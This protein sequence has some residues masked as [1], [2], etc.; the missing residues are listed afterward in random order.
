MRCADLITLFLRVLWWHFKNIFANKQLSG[1]TRKDKETTRQGC[2]QKPP[3]SC[4]AG[5]LNNKGS[6]GSTGKSPSTEGKG[7]MSGQDC[8][9]APSGRNR[10][11]YQR[12]V[13]MFLYHGETECV[14]E[15][16]GI[17]LVN[18]RS[19]TVGRLLWSDGNGLNWI[20]GGKRYTLYGNKL[21]SAT[22]TRSEV[23]R[24]HGIR[25]ADTT[26][27]YPVMMTAH[28]PEMSD[29]MTNTD[30]CDIS[31][32]AYV[33]CVRA[34]STS[35][36]TIIVVALVMSSLIGI[37]RADGTEGSEY[38]DH[39]KE[40]MEKHNPLKVNPEYVSLVRGYILQMAAF[41]VWVFVY[42]PLPTLLS[43]V[44]GVYRSHQFWTGGVHVVASLVLS[45]TSKYTII[46]AIVGTA[47][48]PFWALGCSVAWVLS[49]DPQNVVVCIAVLAACVIWKVGLE[50]QMRPVADPI[51]GTPMTAYSVVKMN[52]ESCALCIMVS[53]LSAAC[54]SGKSET[55]LVIAA[56]V[57]VMSCLL[58]PSEEY[59]VTQ[60]NAKGQV[61]T[62]RVLPKVQARNGI[63]FKLRAKMAATRTSEAM[64]ENCFR[65]Y[66]GMYVS[67]GF[68]YKGLMWVLDHGIEEGKP[69]KFQGETRFAAN[70]REP[71]RIKLEH[72]GITGFGVDG[73][74]VV[75]QPKM[76]ESISDGW[77]TMIHYDPHGKKCASVFYGVW[78]DKTLTGF[79]DAQA[80]DSGSPV[81]DEN[82][83]LEAVYMGGGTGVGVFSPAMPLINKPPVIEPEEIEEQEPRTDYEEKEQTSV[84]IREEVG[85]E[86]HTRVCGQSGELNEIK[87]LKL[88]MFALMESV[89]QMR[90]LLECQGFEFHKKK[91]KNKKRA[92]T[93][94]D[95][96]RKRTSHYRAYPRQNMKMFTD[97]EYEHLLNSGIPKETIAATARQRWVDHCEKN[98]MYTD[99]EQEISSDSDSDESTT[100]GR[101]ARISVYDY[102]TYELDAHAMSGMTFVKKIGANTRIDHGNGVVANYEN[103]VPLEEFTRVS[104]EREHLVEAIE[105]MALQAE[106]YQAEIGNL[107]AEVE[108]LEE[109]RDR[110]DTDIENLECLVLRLKQDRSEQEE[111]KQ[112]L[113]SLINELQNRKVAVEEKEM[114]SAGTMTEEHGPGDWNKQKKKTKVSF[115]EKTPIVKDDLA[116]TAHASKKQPVK[117]PCGE[118]TTVPS[119]HWK[120]AIKHGKCSCGKQTECPKGEVFKDPCKKHCNHFWCAKQMDVKCDRVSCANL[121]CIEK[122]K[123]ISD[124]TPKENG[125][126][127]G[128][129]ADPSVVS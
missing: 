29:A 109:I 67:T 119:G 85:F 105:D 8:G 65:I 54:H 127:G 71:E 128:P 50:L 46:P 69:V 64:W 51:S 90:G 92:Q 125:S 61:V 48:S 40:W 95:R 96:K 19:I 9:G 118:V 103:M 73:P 27:I 6:Y 10:M 76:A 20:F 3:Q 77:K 102:D 43:C 110:R 13:S 16:G 89:K 116:Y 62:V 15:F 123:G 38:A 112:S 93:E 66:S 122:R 117:M 45:L 88:Q 101:H 84:P 22:A 5:S 7:E 47:M 70:K 55:F 121:W 2:E 74:N 11:A 79:T 12:R 42:T 23:D 26:M 25:S 31:R 113:M 17:S 39:V 104:T 52:C 35:L 1:D 32:D 82:G 68:Q 126:V 28:R 87:D 34:G 81:Y 91:G 98:S 106:A 58:M 57:A 94:K 33:P 83:K 59:I 14:D 72:D 80:G 129:S 60:K 75:K 18:V 44:F 114:A 124:M 4:E 97:E 99:R 107:R 120:Y 36:W 108:D 86:S 53:C 24:Y 49:V 21:R 30:I 56:I 111:E 115:E 100:Y 41:V 37:V 78:R 63:W